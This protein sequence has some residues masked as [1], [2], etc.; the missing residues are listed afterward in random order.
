LET[1][2]HNDPRIR[3]WINQ[4]IE[5]IF[6]VC[7]LTGVDSD[8]EFEKGCQIVMKLAS[9]LQ[10]I[11]NFPSEF[12][13]DGVKQLLEQQLPD[14]RVINN[15]PTFQVIMDRMLHEGILKVTDYQK[16]EAFNIISATV[17]TKD[18]NIEPH[19]SY[20]ESPIEVSCIEGVTDSVLPD[21]TTLTIPYSDIQLAQAEAQA[22]ADAQALAEALA[23]AEA[24]AKADAQALAEALAQAEAQA[25]ADAQALAEALAQAEAQAKADAQALAEAL[26]QA[27]A[28]AKAD[29]QALAEA[30]AQA[31]AQAKADAQALAEALAQVNSLTKA[32]MKAKADALAFADALAQVETKLEAITKIERDELAKPMSSTNDYFIEHLRKANS[33]FSGNELQPVELIKVSTLFT[34][35]NSKISQLL[36]AFLVPQQADFLEQVLS[37]IFP[38]G[39]VHWNKSLMG[40]KFLAQAEDILICLYDPEHPCDLNKFNKVGWKVL[41]CNNEDLTFPRRLERQIRQIQRSGKMSAT[42]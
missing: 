32:G 28:Q 5:R 21:F 25:K 26:A 24:Q 38:K 37:N 2:F 16:K 29:A 8:E 36:S 27:E 4:I 40:H 6:T 17:N 41:I 13:A 22:K 11:E 35:I 14:S 42:V 1:Y 33:T 7:I 10:D 9:L 39:T 15:F 31:E 19:D 18:I 23:Q 12:L 30:L 3:K 34:S 20:T